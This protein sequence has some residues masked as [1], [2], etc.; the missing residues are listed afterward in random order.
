M[1]AS[2]ISFPKFKLREGF[3]GP[4]GRSICSLSNK[5]IRFSGN[6][7]GKGFKSPR[8]KANPCPRPGIAMPPGPEGKL[9]FTGA[10]LIY[11][12]PLIIFQI[13]L[14]ISI[15]L[16]ILALIQRKTYHQY[17]KTYIHLIQTF[18]KLS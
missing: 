3:T 4:E 17:L 2:K 9:R 18:Q 1:M 8:L 5:S 15:V 14:T 12:F 7:S 10:Q 16:V 13:Y 11:T 6:P